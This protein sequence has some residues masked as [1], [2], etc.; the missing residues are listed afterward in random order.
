MAPQPTKPSQGKKGTKRSAPDVAE[1]PVP[2]K[3]KLPWPLNALLSPGKAPAQAP[4]PAPLAI[5]ELAL[6]RA[7]KDSPDWQKTSEAQRI[8]AIHTARR[9][10]EAEVKLRSQVQ[11]VNLD[12]QLDIIPTDASWIS[13]LAMFEADL[14]EFSVKEVLDKYFNE[15][16]K[17]AIVPPTTQGVILDIQ[18]TETEEYTKLLAGQ[19]KGTKDN[20]ATKFTML[21]FGLSVAPMTLTN[22]FNAG[23]NEDDLP[24]AKADL[25]RV[26]RIMFAEKPLE[27]LDLYH[28]RSYG[29]PMLRRPKSKAHQ[30]PPVA[31][32]QV[33]METAATGNEQLNGHHQPAPIFPSS[34]TAVGMRGGAGDP[35]IIWGLKD[36]GLAITDEREGSEGAFLE[37]ALRILRLPKET[38]TYEFVVD[39]YRNQEKNKEQSEKAHVKSFPVDQDSFSHVYNQYLK[40]RL[41]NRLRDWPMVVRQASDEMTPHFRIPT[42]MKTPPAR[43]P[44][45]INPGNA[46]TKTGPNLPPPKTSPLK[47]KKPPSPPKSLAKPSPTKKD[48]PN[49]PI[50]N[51]H[52]P[53][54]LG[55]LPGTSTSATNPG[56]NER[57]VYSLDGKRSAVFTDDHKS[58]YE[59]ALKVVK[60][61]LGQDKVNFTVSQ[62]N[63][64]PARQAP[65]GKFAYVGSV[66]YPEGSANLPQY[67]NSV[68]SVMFKEPPAAANYHQDWRIVVHPPISRIVQNWPQTSDLD[69]KVEVPN[70]NKPSKPNNG[71]PSGNKPSGAGAKTSRG[72]NPPPP[73]PNPLPGTR[74]GYIHG[75]GGR[76]LVQN[77]AADFQTAALKLLGI[78]PTSVFHFYICTPGS[79]PSK[80]VMV[81]Q[82][83]FAQ[84]F[85]SEIRPLMPNT[86]H[87]NIFVSKYRLSKEPPLEPEKDKRD[88]V[89]VTYDDD[90]AYWKIPT[91]TKT[92]YGINQ[93]QE[94]F[95][96]AMRVLFPSGAQATVEI[97]AEGTAYTDMGYGGLELTPQLWHR[98]RRDLTSQS[99]ALSYTIK[100]GNEDAEVIGIRLVGNN[101]FA[102]AKLTDYGQMQRE[103]T[104]M[105]IWL[106][107]DSNPTQ[108]RLWK[109]AEDRERNGNSVLINYEPASAAAKEIEKFLNGHPGTKTNCIWF[110]PEFGTL[111][112]TNHG[113]SNKG[114]KTEVIGANMPTTVAALQKLFKKSDPKD[115]KD[116]E[117]IDVHVRDHRFILS[118][119]TTPCQFRKYVSDWFTGEDIH[120]QEN[121]KEVYQVEQLPPWG[122][123][124][125]TPVASAPTT[126]NKPPNTTPV[127]PPAMPTYQRPLPPR[128]NKERILKHRL[129]QPNAQPWNEWQAENNRQDRLQRDSYHRDQSVIEPGQQPAPPIFGPSRQT[130]LS[131]G[132]S[133][134]LP[135]PYFWSITPGDFARKAEEAQ[136]L[137]NSCLERMSRCQLCN[138]TF[139]EYET[140]KIAEHL[141]SHQDALREVGR[142]PLC[143]CCWA[144]LDKQQK[145]EHLWH[146]QKQN[147]SNLM[148]SYWQGLQCPVCDEDLGALQSNDEVLAHMADHPPGLLRFCDRCGVDTTLCDDAQRNQHDQTCFETDQAGKLVFCNRCGK[149]KASE[150]EQ[151]R[152]THDLICKPNGRQFCTVC[153]IEWSSMKDG[154]KHQHCLFHKT[155]G[156]PRKTF[157]KRCGKNISTMNAGQSTAHQQDCYLTEPHIIDTR[158]RIQELENRIAESKRLNAHNKAED[159]RLFQKRAEINARESAIKAKEAALGIKAPESTAGPAR[160][161]DAFNCPLL[162]PDGS[163]CNQRITITACGGQIK[164]HYQHNCVPGVNNCGSTA[165]QIREPLQAGPTLQE[166]YR[167]YPSLK[168]GSDRLQAAA[169]RARAA[170]NSKP[171][172]TK[173]TPPAPED[174]NADK[175]HTAT[176]EAINPPSSTMNKPKS[177]K[178][179]SP[180]TTEPLA[181][182]NKSACAASQLPAEDSLAEDPNPKP[183]KNNDSDIDITS[184]KDATGFDRRRKAAPSARKASGKTPAGSKRKKATI[185]DEEDDVGG[186]FGLMGAKASKGGKRQKTTT[187]RAPSSGLESSILGSDSAE[188]EPL[189]PLVGIRRTTRATSGT[190][191]PNLVP[192]IA[193]KAGRPKGRAGNAQ[194]DEADEEEFEVMRSPGKRA[195]PQSPKKR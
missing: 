11:I 94:E 111:S 21:H 130:P 114:R 68:A 133:M 163:V 181:T 186:H 89:R 143:D 49:P 150:K 57:V 41:Y 33:S 28:E 187:V 47:N 167:L 144:A 61:G 98:V 169:D 59:A 107:N 118:E 8:D 131:T 170:Q 155:P 9:E 18:K 83:S 139:P 123:P 176:P 60:Q 95:V 22:V 128:I 67:L 108:F 5:S 54:P 162:K 146:H 172:P 157:C 16:Q 92:G 39:Q 192:S 104:R 34:P 27:F 3:S 10:L 145:K 179:G 177:P 19:L 56:P 174:P 50:S 53:H 164:A 116:I 190:P 161:P 52:L 32:P 4:T 45:I 105:R 137:R 148:R 124:E 100:L 44:V 138:T 2:K 140:E 91:D 64:T 69:E 30:V 142:C 29:F 15:G 171:N 132:L 75:F 20:L 178:K 189:A 58:F 51:H 194:L 183:T 102:C 193:R 188:E 31:T 13:W 84:K 87:W 165:I 76:F 112:F 99:G 147:E 117:F 72:A 48:P 135:E 1:T 24:D 88:I 153:G 115:I 6:S 97:G 82:H 136:A 126:H 55:G 77:T 17:L 185:E 35:V 74:S 173:P 103:I 149:D 85:E 156:G 122:L 121:V 191:G 62:Y 96:R 70:Y 38:K 26:Q 65:Q 73:A 166:L 109:T 110:R 195:R 80:T 182:A 79:T 160:L 63:N 37:A 152:Q 25:P 93:L 154:E 42:K 7:M 159:A 90:T 106:Q 14:L 125:P 66:K 127:P 129:G 43:R 158:E 120:V 134:N 86:G 119:G 101:S 141:K 180:K 168:D 151:D 71:A 23:K 113:R 81:H 40:A 46:S 78:D 175:F 12:L 184:P 36:V